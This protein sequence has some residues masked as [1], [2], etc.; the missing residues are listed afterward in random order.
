MKALF[1][2]YATFFA[3]Y[4][5]IL[6]SNAQTFFNPKIG[7][8]YY[9]EF[10]THVN[11]DVVGRDLFSSSTGSGAGTPSSSS[12]S[13]PNVV[14]T[15]VS[16]TGTT[17]T[18][19]AALIANNTAIRLGGGKWAFEVRIDSLNIL[20]DGTN[21]YQLIVG[22]GDDGTVVNQTD[23]VYFLYDEGGVSTG[24]TASANWQTVT[25]SNGTRTFNTSSIAVSTTLTTLRFEV[26]PDASQVDFYVNGTHTGTSHTTNIPKGAGRD[27]GI[28]LMIQ[29][30]AGN[31][32]R[33]V[34]W[35]YIHV[36][37]RYNESK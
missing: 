10:L 1:T 23:A 13:R 33:W 37:C 31:S 30:S 26:N 6:P 3:L 9:N 22:L 35:D 29:K 8:E 5:N 2:L 16:T 34:A 32:A 36:T 7:F 17:T 4:A 19:R 18:G 20:S 24:S 28:V 12:S 14:G 15:A 27:T 11:A 21:R 25:S